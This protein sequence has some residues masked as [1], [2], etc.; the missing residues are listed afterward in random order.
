M[1]VYL[2]LEHCRMDTVFK[3]LDFS[4]LYVYLSLVMSKPIALIHILF[5]EYRMIHTQRALVGKREETGSPH[6]I[7]LIIIFTQ[8]KINLINTVRV[9]FLLSK[10]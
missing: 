7:D 10:K 1:Q 2:A 9:W 4:G 5:T 8:T 3:G 6:D